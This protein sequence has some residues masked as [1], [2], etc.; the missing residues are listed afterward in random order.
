MAYAPSPGP[1]RTL[2][3]L[4]AV[5]FFMETL[6]STIVNTALPA[7]AR[8]MGSRPLA[9]QSVVIAY[10]LTLAALIPVSGWMADRFGTRRVYF[11]A[12]A[13]FTLGSAACA[14]A[15]SLPHLV[16][17]RVLQGVGGSM[18]LPVGRLAVLRA[19]PGERYIEALAFVTMPAL[20]GPLAGPPLG[21]W[22]V[23]FASWH[24]IFL[25][26][27]PVG[28][29]CMLAT[30][31][32]MPSGQRR[33]PG[34]FDGWGFLQVVVFMV[35]MS[36][37]LDGL[38]ELGFPLVVVVALI[39]FGLAA[40]AAYVL[41]AV[42]V[43]R[44]LFELSLFRT[45]SF[46]VGIL[47]NFFARL[48]AGS[49]PFLV[50]LFFQLALAATPLAAGLSMLPIAAASILAKPLAAPLILRHGYRRFLVGNTLALGLA[51][52]GFGLLG[53]S[54]AW[55]VRLPLL[56]AFGTLNSLQFTA[57]NTLTLRDL[58]AGQAGA[59]N[60]LYSMVQMLAMS[61][62]VATAG[63][64]LATLAGADGGAHAGFRATFAC[65]GALTCTSAWVFAQLPSARARAPG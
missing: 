35:A 37:G 63:A 14:L 15:P 18:L 42:R 54:T 16:A 40:L 25:I 41:H 53:P 29:A 65:M 60:S 9:M 21:G 5:G 49:M 34:P 50:P 36:L 48:G 6:D 23:E 19:F 4:V 20:V 13:L 30:W 46:A 2:L 57:M 39:T 32:A 47:G 51:M 11:G 8:A 55:L 1:S 64:L 33:D 17:A 28:A 43:P 59:G 45:R 26:N 62:A 12:T 44:P 38:S 58:G 3:A 52:A 61:F 7:M 22:L 27:L 31:R 56:L 10:A 24:W